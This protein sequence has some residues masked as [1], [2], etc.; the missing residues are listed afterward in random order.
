MD[1]SSKT[2][3]VCC[4]PLFVSLAE[5]L[6]RDFGKVYLHIPFAG[7]FPTMNH[8]MVGYGIEGLEIVDGVLGPHFESV[9]LFVFPDLHNAALQIQLEKMGKRV[10]G[11]R[12]AEE[13]EN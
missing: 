1:L 2:V 3:L 7:S 5:R 13:L 10:F 11:N 9:D 4:N 8:G 12:N 6:T